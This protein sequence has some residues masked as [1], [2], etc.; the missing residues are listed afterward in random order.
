MKPL[1]Y[2]SLLQI[3]GITFLSALLW[4]IVGHGWM[5]LTT[6]AWIL[7]FWLVKDI[8][9]Y[10]LYRPAL[11]GRVAI[12]TAALRGHQ[13]QVIRELAPQGQV[14]VRGERWSAVTRG[15]ET[16]AVGRPVRIVDANGM[17]LIVVPL[18]ASLPPERPD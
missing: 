15:G 16:V 3:P 4:W 8:L 10:P 11:A 1:T 18:S 7:G 14:L 2:Y 6:A 13:A 12:G 17:T 9:L 5:S